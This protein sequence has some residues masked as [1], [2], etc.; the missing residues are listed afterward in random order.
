MLIIGI[1]GGTGCGKTT[2]VDLLQNIFGKEELMVIHQDAYY[3]D[4]GSIPLEERQKINFDH[5][6]SIDY[7]LLLEHLKELMRGKSIEMPQYSFISCT[8][9]NNTITIFPSRV[10]IVEGILVLGYQALRD[11]F[12]VKV[13]IDTNEDERLARV[14]ERDTSERGRDLKEVHD[15]YRKIVKPAHEKFI[16]PTRGFADI[17]IPDGGNNSH[18]LRVLSSIIEDHLG[19][20]NQGL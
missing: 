7:R 16:E 9:L 20:S 17:F 3:K 14:T 1:A 13:Y 6:D 11:I 19:R 15:R 8:R 10:I 18:S 12:D 4:N 2:L 5:P